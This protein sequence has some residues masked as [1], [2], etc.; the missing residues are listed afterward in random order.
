LA[1][2]WTKSTG[3]TKKDFIDDVI[4]PAETR[5]FLCQTLEFLLTLKREK[6]ERLLAAWPTG[7]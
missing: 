1:A 5:K 2:A 6:S 3:S 4:H 7:F